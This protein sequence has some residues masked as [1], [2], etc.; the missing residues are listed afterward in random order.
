MGVL[1]RVEALAD[2]PD[3]AAS[4]LSRPYERI[5]PL[6]EVI[7]ACLNCGAESRRVQALYFDML[8]KLG[9]ELDILRS[10][11]LSDIEIAGGGAVAEG[12]RRLRA[13]Q[14]RLSAGYDGEYGR[15]S[16]FDP[17]ELEMLAGQIAMA[18]LPALTPR[19]KRES[20]AAAIPRAEASQPAKMMEGLNPEQAMAV[21]APESA[22]AVIAGPG[23]GKTKTLVERIAHL[24]EAGIAKPS[25]ITAV[26]FTNQAAEEMRRRLESRLG[27]RRA[28]RGITIGTFHAICLGLLDKKPL[29]SEADVLDI[30]SGL[31][32]APADRPSL[33]RLAAAISQAK[34][35]ITPDPELAPMLAAYNGALQAIGARDLD[36]L[37]LDALSLNVENR[38]M[39]HHVLVDEFQDINAVQRQLV[40]HFS[41]HARSLFVIGDPD[42]SIYGFRGADATCFQSLKAMLPSLRIISLK[43]NYRSTPEILDAALSV[44]A[45]NPGGARDL[46]ANHPSGMPVR[47]LTAANPFAEGVFIAREIARMTGGMD[48]LNARPADVPRAFSDIAVLCRTRRQLAQIETCLRH[49]DIPCVVT[50][51]EDYLNDD[52][53]RGV[54]AFFRALLDPCD[55]TALRTSLHLAFA[56]APEEMARAEALAEKITQPES[57]AESTGFMGTLGQWAA[58]VAR[59]QPL[60]HR[61]KPRRLLEMWEAERGKSAPLDRLKD[62]SL[63]YSD[64][65]GFIDGL[66]LGQE[67]DIRRAAGRG[68]ASGAVRLMTLHGSKGLEFPV[69]FLAGVSRESLPLERSD[70]PTDLEEERRLFF[71]GI[72]RARE[73]LIITAP[74]EPSSFLAELPA[75]VKPAAIPAD[76]KVIHGQQLSFL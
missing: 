39:F 22:V 71:V 53:V 75:T 64:M 46:R 57:L 7:A 68:Y 14:V 59:F 12:I 74:D 44:I 28:L 19:K 24:I 35:G 11:P 4:P 1:N 32:A 58:C 56:A 6:P 47:L 52:G 73:E 17:G 31:P 33:R 63:F 38:A 50:G 21:S 70:A 61:T 20:A 67:A 8:K 40:V 48:M 18:G 23:T 45:H 49:D 30:L 36:D 41:R 65:A 27:G 54:L 29:V 72:T 69:V 26:T 60:V 15:I 66:L 37:L 10:T 42:Q 62:A 2:R 55:M 5:V 51:R 25:E 16:L 9:P 34:S 76:R 3:G 43:Q 13:G